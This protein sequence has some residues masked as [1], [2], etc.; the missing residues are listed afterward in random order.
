MTDTGFSAL[1]LF[2]VDD[3]VAVV[4]GGASGLGRIAALTLAEAG[5]HVC[6]TDID[7]NKAVTKY[8]GECGC[9]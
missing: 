8:G 6:V 1:K 7:H 2:R 5:A 3:D 9:R 4:T